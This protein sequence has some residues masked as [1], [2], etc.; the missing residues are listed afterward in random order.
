[1]SSEVDAVG[2][3]IGGAL[4]SYLR[5][6]R[7]NL[8]PY[9]RLYSKMLVQAFGDWFSHRSQLLRNNGERE[10]SKAAIAENA[11][12]WIMSDVEWIGVKKG[13]RQGTVSF[14][15]VCMALD[16]DPAAIRRVLPIKSF[17]EL[18]RVGRVYL[19]SR[20]RGGDPEDPTGGYPKGSE[21]RGIPKRRGGGEFDI[22][23][24]LSDSDDRAQ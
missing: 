24:A 20:S 5:D 15:F 22:R 11:F 1:M 8:L 18:E 3:F 14:V 6:L 4:A 13:R 21:G 2:D 9:E 12:A 17:A 19:S 10:E 23:A 16:L 7:P